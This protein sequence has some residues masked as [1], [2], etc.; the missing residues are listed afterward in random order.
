MIDLLAWLR[1]SAGL[2]QVRKEWRPRHRLILRRPSDGENITLDCIIRAEDVEI[3]TDE[4][5]VLHDVAVEVDLDRQSM[6]V[7][8]ANI[9]TAYCLGRDGNISGYYH[10]RDDD[11]RA[12]VSS[13]VVEQGV[14]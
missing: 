13:L 12:R 1:R 3:A 11:E 2:R 7:H 6:C 4:G 10:W 5:A 8:P 9:I 14:R